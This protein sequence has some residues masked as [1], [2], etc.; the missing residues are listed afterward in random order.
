MDD[1]P[2]PDDDVV[3]RG[4]LQQGCH[5]DLD[6][7]LRHQFVEGRGIRERVRSLRQS[8]SDALRRHHL[9]PL[10]VQEH[11]P[12]R[13]RGRDRLHTVRTHRRRPRRIVGQ[14]EQRLAPGVRLVG[15]LI[16]EQERGQIIVRTSAGA[17][18][19]RPR[20]HRHPALAGVRGR[21]G[22]FIN[23]V[24]QVVPA[25]RFG[26]LGRQRGRARTRPRLARGVDAAVGQRHL[27]DDIDILDDRGDTAGVGQRLEQA[28]IRRRDRVGTHRLHRAEHGEGLVPR[29]GHLDADDRVLQQNAALHKQSGDQ[30]LRLER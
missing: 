18:L 28:V 25:G 23:E 10:A 3:G 7:A 4:A 17:V 29:A 27:P 8:L 22:Q 11:P 12:A 1:V 19:R 24:Q 5:G 2:R 30:F 16:I 13:G 26:G 6:H 15:V 9:H 14:F 20:A 21:V